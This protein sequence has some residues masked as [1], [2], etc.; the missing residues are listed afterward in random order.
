MAAGNR[1][2][3]ASK[4]AKPAPSSSPA[5]SPTEPPAP[6]PRSPANSTLIF[7]ISVTDLAYSPELGSVGNNV[8][9]PGGDTCPAPTDVSHFVN[10]PEG[11]QPVTHTFNLF[12]FSEADNANGTLIDGLQVTGGNITGT[13]AKNF[14]LVGGANGPFTVTYTPTTIGATSAVINLFSNDAGNPDYTFTVTGTDPSSADL[15]VSTGKTKFPA[16]IVSG[17]GTKLSLPLTITNDGN[18]PLAKNAVTQV[19]IF[20]VNTANGTQTALTAPISSVS[21]SNLAAGKSKTLTETLTIPASVDAGTYKLAAVVNANAAV[22]E[23]NTANDSAV[24]TQTFTL[25]AG[26]YDLTGALVSSKLPTTVVANQPVKGSLSLS[27]QNAG[28][29]VLPKGQ[30]VTV[31]V[32]AHNLSD[33]T[34]TTIGTAHESLSAFKANL[35]HTF[36]VP[37]NDAAGLAAGNYQY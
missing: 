12:D 37:I 10:L 9:L 16:S 5:P 14:T 11:Q 26:F 19:Q 23:T 17:A 35:A 29:I 28:N 34:E 22:S 6:L 2:S 3:K 30:G 20:L 27:I 36:S 13:G 1:A 15:T 32:V 33:G 18:S 4:T 8:H 25:A 7:D 24:T 21:V 31:T